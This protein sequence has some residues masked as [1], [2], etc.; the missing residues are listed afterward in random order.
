M[1]SESPFKSHNIESSIPEN[2]ELDTPM[3]NYIDHLNEHHLDLL[4]H[5]RT[6]T[7]SEYLIYYQKSLYN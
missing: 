4:P 1:A 7:L 3:K 2:K 6:R 5:K